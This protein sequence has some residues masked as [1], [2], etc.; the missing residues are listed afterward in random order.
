MRRLVLLLLL[1]P[2]SCGLGY[3]TPASEVIKDMNRLPTPVP[4]VST[5]TAKQEQN[6]IMESWVGSPISALIA[7][8]GAPTSVVPDGSGGTIYVYRFHVSGPLVGD[9]PPSYPGGPPAQPST[10][11]VDTSYDQV[12]EFYVT[13]DGVIYS[14]RWQGL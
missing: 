13:A 9:Q 1:V 2:V 14:W 12:R 8:W 5:D 3:L 7:S 6:K 10:V 4:T 11:Y